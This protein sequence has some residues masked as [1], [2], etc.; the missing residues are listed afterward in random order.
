MKWS[1]SLLC[2]ARALPSR[3]ALP[4]WDL[5]R[6]NSRYVSLAQQDRASVS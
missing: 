3:M 5:G 2:A 4:H 1:G 6:Y